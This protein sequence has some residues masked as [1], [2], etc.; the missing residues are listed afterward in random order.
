L[1]YTHKVNIKREKAR[2]LQQENDA[3]SAGETKKIIA[4][5]WPDAEVTE[6]GLMY[7]ITKKG[8]GAK[9]SK[10]SFVKVHYTGTLLLDGK[11]F[12]SS[13]DRN[14]PFKFKVGAGS[15]IKG[16]DEAVMDM[17]KGEQRTIIV[18]PELG[19][20]TRGAGRGLIPPNA[21][22]VFDIELL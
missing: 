6:S 8:D 5:K 10:G 22:L 15:V 13:R 7:V 2:A 1:A 19:Y 3:S 4:Q 18:P 12:D 21:T 9:P 20:G 16:W 17:K 14:K 11:K